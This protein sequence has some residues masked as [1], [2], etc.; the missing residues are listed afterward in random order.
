M[1]RE[2]GGNLEY[3]NNPR[4]LKDGNAIIT[5]QTNRNTLIKTQTEMDKIKGVVK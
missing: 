5:N 2:A 4:H 3:S 1:I